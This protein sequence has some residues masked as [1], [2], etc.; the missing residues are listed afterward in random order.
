MAT[1]EKPKPSERVPVDLL[2]VIYDSGVLTERQFADLRAKVQN[3]DYPNEPI[4]AGG[5][6]RRGDES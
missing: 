2:P 6:A 5:S 3:G 4:G 1:F